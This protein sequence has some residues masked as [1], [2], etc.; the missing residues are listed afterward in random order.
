MYMMYIVYILYIMYTMYMDCDEYAIKVTSKS[1]NHIFGFCSNC[2]RKVAL[3][4]SEYSEQAWREI[5]RYVE[6]RYIRVRRVDD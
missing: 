6:F 5:Q 3:M 2:G 1:D 4:S